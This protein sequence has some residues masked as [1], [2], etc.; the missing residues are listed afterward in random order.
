MYGTLCHPEQGDGESRHAAN[1]ALILEK[2]VR[3]R[4]LALGL[5]LDMRFS[6][7]KARG[8]CMP[9]SASCQCRV[10]VKEVIPKRH[11]ILSEDTTE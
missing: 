1:I 11:S 2:K 10:R 9:R 8:Q 4:Y 5:V 6:V 3:L 7:C